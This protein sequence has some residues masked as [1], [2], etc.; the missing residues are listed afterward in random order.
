MKHLQTRMVA[1]NSEEPRFGTEAAAT[2]SGT[3]S[4]LISSGTTNEG[5]RD[6]ERLIPTGRTKRLKADFNDPLDW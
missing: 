3:C 2:R 1:N 5:I 6:Y 4:P